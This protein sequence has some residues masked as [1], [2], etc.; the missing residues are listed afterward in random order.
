[1]GSCVT[2]RGHR[3]I[4]LREIKH[5]LRPGLMTVHTLREVESRWAVR[6]WARNAVA[7]KTRTLNLR[8]KFRVLFTSKAISY[9]S[10]FAQLLLGDHRQII[11]Y[12][13]KV[14][15]VLVDYLRLGRGTSTQNAIRARTCIQAGARAHSGLVVNCQAPGLHWQ[16]ERQTFL[17]GR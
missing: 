1:M 11:L 5:N 9:L 8:L 13:A 7:R 10:T 16:P 6:L 12:W 15:R 3:I 14:G 4:Y 17:Y 2:T